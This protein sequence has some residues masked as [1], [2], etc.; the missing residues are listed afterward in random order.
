M[1]YLE[2]ILEVGLIAS[3]IV[4]VLLIVLSFVKKDEIL[5]DSALAKLKAH[6][7]VFK[8][9]F[10]VAVLGLGLFLLVLYTEVLA[11]FRDLPLGSV[12][13]NASQIALTSLSLVVLT[14]S[15][16]NLYI[17]MKLLESD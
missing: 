4:I 17:V 12:Y 1:V 14:V 16:L 9:V 7:D 6:Y 2:N 13:P 5:S 8:F 10:P 15:L 3:T 11:W